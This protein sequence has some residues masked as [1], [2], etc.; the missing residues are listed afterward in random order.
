MKHAVN[1]INCQN[2]WHNALPIGN[3]YM[4][5]M[6]CYNNNSLGFTLNHY[7]V[8]YRMHKR[9]SQAAQHSAPPAF[10]G[11][12]YEEL[13]KLAEAKYLDFRKGP[14][15]QYFESLHQFTSEYGQCHEG[16]SHPPTGEVILHLADTMH[17][18]LASKLQLQIE[19]A[20]IIFEA[21]GQ[22]NCTLQSTT[23]MLSASC[24]HTQIQHSGNS[25]ASVALQF[26][27][28]RLMNDY[29]V[30][31]TQI[32]GDTICQT[33]QFYPNEEDS[34]K[35]PPYTFHVLLRI[36]GGQYSIS[37]DAQAFSICPENTSRQLDILTYVHARPK[38][39][40]TVEDAAAALD[41]I[42]SSLST[43]QQEHKARWQAFWGKSS[44]SL[45]DTML[46]TLWYLN[47]YL[48][49]C[50]SGKD[51]GMPEQACGLNG[52]WDIRRPTVW[53]S[54]WYWDV[55]IQA[56]FWPVYTAN[57]PE[58]GQLFTDGLLTYGASAEAFAQNIYGLQGWAM[59]FP[60]VLY[61][62]IMPWCAQFLW[63]QYEYTGDVE[64]LKNKAYP[65]IQNILSFAM[66][67]A[68]KDAET[69][70]YYYYPDVSPEQ[71]PLTR[72]STITLSTVRYLLQIALQCIDILG[73]PKE[74]KTEYENFLAQLSPYP[75][76]IDAFGTR[77]K[78]SE[79][80]PNNL[81]LRHPSLLMPI[82]PIGEIS[83][84]SSKAELEK[85]RN[86]LRYAQDNTEIGVFG[87]G[88]LSCAASRL[89]DGATALRLIYEKGIDYIIRSNGLAYEETDRWLNHCVIAQRPLYYPPMMEGAGE[90]TAAI[91][92]MLLQSYN[93]IIHVFAALPGESALPEEASA[94]Y[95][96]EQKD[97]FVQYPSW[98]TCEFSNLLAKGGFLVSARFEHGSI[99]WVH[100]ISQLGDT[101]RLW[102]NFP[103]HI[104]IRQ[105]NSQAPVTFTRAEGIICFNT[106][107]KAEYQIAGSK[108]AALPYRQSGTKYPQ[109][110]LERTAHSHR[111]V[112]IGENEHTHF[113]KS[114]DGF[115]YDY[116]MGNH[117]ISHMTVYKF[118]FGM[119]K[120]NL[121]KNYE[122]FAHRQIIYTEQLMSLAENFIQ[123]NPHSQYT[124]AI[125][126]GFTKCADL[127]A[128][129]RG[130]PD[131]LRQD[132]IQGKQATEFWVELP[133]GRYSLLVVSG[134]ALNESCTTILLPST[135]AVYGGKTL[136]KNRYQSEI[137]SV[138][139][140]SGGPLKLVFSSPDNSTWNVSALLINKEHAL[141]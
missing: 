12:T 107:P 95:V 66:A 2:D 131:E 87:Y 74:E 39:N 64:H 123:I 135:G 83:Q 90:M 1:F 26:P 108:I 17:N 122:N 58:I 37:A 118:D 10:S 51:G 98:D 125:G 82:Y 59:D 99:E 45:P 96:H 23:I 119:G 104:S 115:I 20:Q 80:A 35:Y 68:R 92:E 137:I 56:A 42:Q 47:L 75:T 73:Y 36:S 117:R 111:R 40:S 28:R 63:W 9:Y 4:G 93:G 127:H 132:F 22:N 60:H 49:E 29:K 44:V 30:T 81:W 109:N 38:G 43:H 126:Y 100:I 76:C 84:H 88:W 138:T 86:T 124:P 116:C 136:H 78:D 110:I 91:N 65:A 55:N 54:M 25:L 24:M 6:A 106:Q 32:A 50:S 33:V 46:E 79:H 72:N 69:N 114:Y 31:Y 130:F 139:H 102:D 53:G 71:G 121:N 16:V 113:I 11:R 101:L 27:I 7:Q 3:S 89:G 52:L 13:V 14:V 15:H 70:K 133:Q 62:S 94:F 105:C 41:S 21:N 97:R 129:N 128:E 103:A 8:Y 141:Y 112:F 19:D 140:S 48:L 120:N 34:S 18:P 61:N 77:L 57:H 5:A 134:D 67:V 85:G